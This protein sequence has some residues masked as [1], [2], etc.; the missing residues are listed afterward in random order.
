MSL[1]FFTSSLSS[2]SHLTHVG[3]FLVFTSIQWCS[4]VSSFIHTSKL[5]MKKNFRHVGG[6]NHCDVG[7]EI[8]YT[9][10]NYYLPSFCVCDS[11]SAHNNWK[12]LMKKIELWHEACFWWWLVKRQGKKSIISVHRICHI[13]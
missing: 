5:G 7:L 1:T 3:F 8:V 4:N 13:S 2:R 10:T 6:F 9:C 12:V 11:L